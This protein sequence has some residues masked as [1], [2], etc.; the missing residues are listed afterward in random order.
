MII[1]SGPILAISLADNIHDLTTRGSLTLYRLLVWILPITLA[2][3]I[4]SFQLLVSFS[5]V[6]VYWLVFVNTGIL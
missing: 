5:V 1:V 6:G 3:F 4:Q 2:I